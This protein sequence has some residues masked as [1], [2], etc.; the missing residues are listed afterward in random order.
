[1]SI[2]KSATSGF[3]WLSVSQAVRQIMQF[4]TTIILVRLLSP[5]DFGLVG[6]ATVVTGFVGIFKDLGTS[7]ALIQRKEISDKLLQSVFWINIFF[8]LNSTVF[9]FALSPLMANVYQEPQVEPVLKLLSLSFIISSL[10]ISQQAILERNLEFKKLSKIEI[11]ATVSGAVTGIGAATLKA[12]VWSLIWQTLAIVTTTSTLLWLTTNWKPKFIF[13]WAEAKSIINYSGNLTGFNIFNYFVRNADN[14]LVGRFLGAESLGYYALAY[15]IMLYPIQNISWVVVRLSFP[16][17]S[18]LQNDNSLFRSAYLEVTCAIACAAFPLMFGLLVLSEPL[19]MTVFGSNWRPVISLLLILIPVGIVQ[20]IGTTA[21]VIYQAKGR[22]DWMLK[23]GITTGLLAVISFIIGLNWGIV[24]VAGAYAITVT[25]L[26]YPSFLIPFKLIDLKILDFVR[27]M[28]RPV[29][30]ST[31]MLIL[32]MLTSELAQ[33][34]K[35]SSMLNL[36]LSSVVG[37]VIYV[38]FS[39]II[40]R[41]QIESIF[42]TIKT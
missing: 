23:W 21:G 2:K 41:E 28:V 9:L 17:F 8:G 16:L 26:S 7:S 40:N 20:S 36:C 38:L 33:Y 35:L 42:A 29:I 5:T 19:V 27:Y 18:K 22:T 37:F 34:L 15:K 6:M 12:G 32:V 13:D 10:S 39:W 11:T 24:G 31:L 4:A 30:C 25:L 1:M 14:A 3:R